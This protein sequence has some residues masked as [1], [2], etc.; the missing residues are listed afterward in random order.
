MLS[1]YIHIQTATKQDFSSKCFGN[2]LQCFLLAAK[3]V[4][5]LL[6][7]QMPSDSVTSDY[8]CVKILWVAKH[9]YTCSVDV[10]KAFDRFP[11]EKLSIMLREYGVDGRLLLAVIS[12][13]SCLEVC[14]RVGRDKS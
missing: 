12:L 5:H 4:L 10:E 3:V 9:D 11:C 14:V 2:K 1:F 7:Q 6:F 8:F 13:Y